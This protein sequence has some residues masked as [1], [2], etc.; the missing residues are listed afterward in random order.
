MLKFGVYAAAAAE[1]ALGGQALAQGKAVQGVTKDEVV[2]GSHTDLSGPAAIWGVSVTNGLRM[3]L[4][5]VNAT[6]GVHGDRKSV[7]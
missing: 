3:R 7:V 5:E 2:I 6:G 1:V 4:D